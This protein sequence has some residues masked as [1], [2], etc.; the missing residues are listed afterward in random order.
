MNKKIIKLEQVKLDRKWAAE[1]GELLMLIWK[2]L[3]KAGFQPT[4]DG[5][6]KCIQLAKKNKI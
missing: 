1:R 3:H 4:V 2:K 6:D 5:L